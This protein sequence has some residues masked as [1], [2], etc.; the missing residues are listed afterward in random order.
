MTRETG[1]LLLHPILIAVLDMEDD[2]I[3]EKAILTKREIIHFPRGLSTLECHMLF[4]LF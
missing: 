4:K 3:K 2:A 1:L